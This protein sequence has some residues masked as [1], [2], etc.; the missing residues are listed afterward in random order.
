MPRALVVREV[1]DA[2]FVILGEGE[3]RSE[4]ERRSELHL[5]KHVLL[6][7]FR[8]RH[9]DLH[10]GVRSV[11]HELGDRRAGHVAARRDGRWQ[12]DDWHGRGGI[13]EAIEDRETGLLVPPHD[14]ASL[15][16]AIVALLKDEPWRKRMGQ[17]GLRACES[18]VQRRA[19]GR[20]NDEGVR[21]ART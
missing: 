14:A 7:G 21:A 19:D 18:I 2:R 5:E 16:S 9:P 3:L 8:D 1:P 6:P 20:G 13:P 15:A 17:A 11:R 4:L 10:Q 12:G